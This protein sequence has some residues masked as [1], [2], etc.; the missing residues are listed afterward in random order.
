MFALP[1]ISQNDRTKKRT[2]RNEAF[3]NAMQLA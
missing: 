1:E 2:S 3:I